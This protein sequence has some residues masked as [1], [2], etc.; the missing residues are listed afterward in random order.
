VRH[1]L[2]GYGGGKG[3]G[4]RR[5]HWRGACSVRPNVRAEAPGADGRLARASDDEPWRS[6]GQGGR[7]WRVASRARG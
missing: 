7:P 1:G 4:V 6:P 5:W 2:V 3:G